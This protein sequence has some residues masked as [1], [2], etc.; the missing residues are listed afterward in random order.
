[1]ID[2]LLKFQAL[3]SAVRGFCE[4]VEGIEG[5]KEQEWLTLVSRSV[6]ELHVS[7]VQFS[8]VDTDYKF[9]TLPDLDARF[10][11]FCRLKLFFNECDNYQFGKSENAVKGEEGSLADD[12]TD[13]YLELKRGLNVLDAG[14]F[15]GEEEVLKLWQAGYLLHWGQHLVDAQRQ[16]YQLRVQSLYLSVPAVRAK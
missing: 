8:F 12:L 3:T 16:L 9:F 1:M 11:L 13:I 7:M 10:D 6:A 2:R 14:V 5:L 15:N 4:L